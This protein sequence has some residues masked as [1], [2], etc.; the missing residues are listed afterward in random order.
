MP[1]KALRAGIAYLPES[2]DAFITSLT[3]S[4]LLAGFFLQVLHLILS[5]TKICSFD[6]L[7]RKLTKEEGKQRLQKTEAM[8]D[9]KHIH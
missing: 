5:G 2:R 3:K 6:Q 9:K 1:F 8:S 7:E 4:K